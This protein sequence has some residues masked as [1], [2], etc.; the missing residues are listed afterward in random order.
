[1][2]SV[3]NCRPIILITKVDT[4]K[5]KVTSPTNFPNKFVAIRSETMKKRIVRIG[6]K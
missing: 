2:L 3:I 4:R 1:M 5:I 6:P